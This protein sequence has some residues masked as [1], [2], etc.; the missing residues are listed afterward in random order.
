MSSCT[1]VSKVQGDVTVI[2]HVPGRP[3]KA[4]V[5]AYE[6]GDAMRNSNVAPARR[7]GLFMDYFGARELSADGTAIVLAAVDWAAG[8][9]TVNMPP[10][11][12]LGDDITIDIAEPLNLDAT[13][14]DDGLPLFSSVA[15]D[16]QQLAGSGTATFG[17]PNAEDTVIT[18]STPGIYVV[19]LT[20]TDGETSTTERITITVTDTASG[21]T[22]LLVTNRLT[23][24][25]PDQALRDHFESLGFA[26]QILDDDDVSAGPDLSGID[27]IYISSTVTA[28]KVG[29][30][31]T[32]VA[33]PLITNE[34][35]LLDDLGMAGAPLGFTDARRSLTIVDDTHPLAGGLS[36]VVRYLDSSS[37]VGCGEPG[38]EA[39]VVAT[40]QGRSVLF[41]YDAG[42]QMVT[43][44][45]PANRILFPGGYSTPR[46]Y[47]LAGLTLLTAAVNA[48][49]A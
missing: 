22:I 6:L 43:G 27:L 30:A 26:V 21:G 16:W 9:G 48:A 24:A 38:T 14:T 12:D 7:V 10:N 28:G 25:R 46:N 29:T 33:I 40:I 34:H 35:F 47:N 11:V 37:R 45:A 44:T 20:A 42:D 2:A 15:S 17:T 1:W 49:L 19:E 18:F 13:V 4:T 41:M 23:L 39:T 5:F 31:F 8:G 32:D 3:E 36:G